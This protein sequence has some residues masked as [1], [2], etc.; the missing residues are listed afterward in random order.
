MDLI[1]D[2]DIEQVAEML[3]TLGFE[4]T[5]HNNI[6]EAKLKDNSGRFHVLG[7]GICEKKVYLD[8]HRDSKLHFAFIGVDYAKKPAK[9]CYEILKLAS[10]INVKAEIS[11]GTSWFNRR[12]KAFLRGIKI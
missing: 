5:S 11:G 9:I 1:I 6:I 10:K 2:A 7:I 3:R 8:V 4:I 12:N